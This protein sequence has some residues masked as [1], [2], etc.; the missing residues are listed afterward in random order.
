MS[1]KLPFIGNLFLLH[2]D[3]VVLFKKSIQ[4]LISEITLWI[5]V[6]FLDDIKRK[7]SYACWKHFESI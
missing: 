3:Q 6:N 1:I 2:I 7:M 4:I 5:S